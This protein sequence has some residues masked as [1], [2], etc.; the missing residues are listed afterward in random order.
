MWHF[1]CDK[2]NLAEEQRYWIVARYVWKKE[3][4]DICSK[5]LFNFNLIP[6][7]YGSKAALHI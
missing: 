5:E 6:N 3:F 1:L 7:I 2:M 4:Y